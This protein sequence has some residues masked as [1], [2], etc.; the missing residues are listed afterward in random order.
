MAVS[1]VTQCCIS[2]CRPN[3]LE[4]W[5]RV[6][7]TPSPWCWLGESLSTFTIS[8][9]AKLLSRP[10][11]WLSGGTRGTNTTSS[12]SASGTPS[13]HSGVE[14]LV[15][16]PSVLAMRIGS[17]SVEILRWSVSVQYKV[18]GDSPYSNCGTQP[19]FDP[20]VWRSIRLV[21]TQTRDL[22]AGLV[23]LT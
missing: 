13:G 7:S 2:S 20:T 19:G 15:N 6:V 22:T 21:Q 8:S 14:S 3:L 5:Q 18:E 4:V 16:V 9:T 11:S 1:Q 17:C 23:R 12:S 10:S